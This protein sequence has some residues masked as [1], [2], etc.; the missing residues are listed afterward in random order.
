M[1]FLTQ[2]FKIGRRGYDFNNLRGGGGAR[3][4]TKILHFRLSFIA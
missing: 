1:T 3:N 2:K 4:I